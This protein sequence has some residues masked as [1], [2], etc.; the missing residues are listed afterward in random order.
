[1]G[2]RRN[3]VWGKEEAFRSSLQPDQHIITKT[4]EKSTEEPTKV[5]TQRRHCTRVRVSPP[6]ISWWRI[7][8]CLC[9]GHGCYKHSSGSD[10]GQ[11]Y[12]FLF[13]FINIRS[14][15]SLLGGKLKSWWLFLKMKLDPMN[16]GLFVMAATAF[17]T[18]LGWDR[19]WNWSFK[20]V[21]SSCAMVGTLLHL[22]C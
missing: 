21:K 18:F 12:Q 17:N 5:S 19:R 11:C 2:W 10:K 13:L 4:V 20:N 15:G 8:G 16:I 22:V 9:V 1:M 14:I 3:L 6:T 7:G